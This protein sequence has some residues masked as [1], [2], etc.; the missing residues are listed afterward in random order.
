VQFQAGAFD[1]WGP[2]APGYEACRKLTGADFESVFYLDLWASNM[3]MINF[4]MFYGSVS[5]V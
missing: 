4:Y 3:K 1:P 2:H 5:L